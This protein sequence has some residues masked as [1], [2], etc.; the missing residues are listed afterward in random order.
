MG[1]QPGW[2]EDGADVNLLRYWDGSSWTDQFMPSGHA[3]SAD[4]AQVVSRGARP[5]SEVPLGMRREQVAHDLAIAYINNRFGVEV[6]GEFSIRSSTNLDNVVDDVSGEGEVET[7][8]HPGIHDLE[9]VRVGTGQRH[10]FGI[11]PEKMELVPTG[12]YEVDGILR[13]MIE[14]YRAAYSR[15]LELLDGG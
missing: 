14:E 10:F 9:M 13:S 11:G 1:A 7:Q 4:H 8:R 6:A 3:S 2:Y 5:T 12:R 15:I